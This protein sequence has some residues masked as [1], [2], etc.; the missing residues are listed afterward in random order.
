MLWFQDSTADLYI[1]LNRSGKQMVGEW[2]I[3]WVNDC[4]AEYKREKLRE[5]REGGYRWVDIEGGDQLDSDSLGGDDMSSDGGGDDGAI[6]IRVPSDTRIASSPIRREHTPSG[7]FTSETDN[8]TCELQCKH[9]ND[10]S[11]SIT[12]AVSLHAATDTCEDTC[13]DTCSETSS[14]SCASSSDDEETQVKRRHLDES[15]P[16]LPQLRTL[17]QCIQ[18]DVE[19]LPRH[20][21]IMTSHS[22]DTNTNTSESNM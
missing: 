2:V 1:W 20:L 6:A 10:S 14:S 16:P 19:P 22:P 11:E 18:V 5:A 17:T 9:K 13:I 7:D 12:N 15:P 4:R 3:A 8:I 21:T